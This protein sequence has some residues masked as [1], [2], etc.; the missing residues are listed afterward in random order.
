MKHIAPF[1]KKI[2]DN[3]IK[4][5]NSYPIIGCLNMEN[6][7]AP[8]LQQMKAQLR[9][10]V[11][12]TMTKRRLMKIAI[13]Q[14]KVKGI[15]KIKDYL[16]GMPALLFT[17]EDPFKLNKILQKS[18]S[19]APAKPRQTAPEDITISAGPTPFAPGP[20]IGELSKLGLKTGV[21][22][23]KIVIKEDKIVV[24]KGETIKEDIASILLRLDIKPMEIGLNLVAVLENGEIIP[25]EVLTVSEE[26]YLQNLQKAHQ[27]AF[28]LSIEAGLVNKDNISLLLSKAFN[29]A[30]TLALEK[31]I[32]SD[33]VVIEML[34]K[35][36]K[37]ALN[38]KEEGKI[39]TEVKKEEKNE[40]EVKEEVK[41]EIKK[42]EV[43]ETKPEIREES[44]EEKPKEKVKEQKIEKK[45]EKEEEIKVEK[46]E[47]KETDKKV[48]DMVKK[49]KDFASGKK[50]TADDVLKS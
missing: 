5:F 40:S 45:E 47:P 4:L 27:W 36:E 37:T 23:N 12:M 9:G 18:K 38:I 19:N 39:E 11:V 28:N 15:E 13:D 2:V 22:A 31:N 49:A 33:V 16:L 41:P 44:K 3:L 35:A 48:N 25:K 29:E 50:I 14:C 42:E 21:E 43:K 46:K 17:K 1:K 26:E 32:I 10:K 8:Q 30:K 34:S 20:V 6:L 7:P 24:K